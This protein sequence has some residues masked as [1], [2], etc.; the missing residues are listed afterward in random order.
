VGIDYSIDIGYGFQVSDEVLGELAKRRGL[1]GED[2]DVIWDLIEEY[3]FPEGIE[4]LELM[5]TGDLM[6]NESMNT[7]VSVARLTKS[8]DLYEYVPFLVTPYSTRP[9][10]AEIGNLTM[11]TLELGLDNPEFTT[12]VTGSVS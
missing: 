4:G 12:F 6:N 10:L 11:M 7:F 1:P 8:I 9:T 5:R 3:T 2:P